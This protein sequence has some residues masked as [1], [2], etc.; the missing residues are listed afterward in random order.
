MF[1]VPMLSPLSSVPFLTVTN[2]EHE[3]SYFLPTNVISLAPS[4]PQPRLRLVSRRLNVV[5]SESPISVSIF[6]R[7]F[8]TTCEASEIDFDLFYVDRKVDRLQSVEFL[9]SLTTADD[10]MTCACSYSVGYGT[11]SAPTCSHGRGN[12]NF[13]LQF[14]LQ[15]A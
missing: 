9:M 4:Q 6:S 13:L 8:F 2:I 3:L 12:F 1:L 10:Q 7:R 5:G 15:F 14:R 11:S